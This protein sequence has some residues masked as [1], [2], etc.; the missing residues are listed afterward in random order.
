MDKP[1]RS[2]KPG[3]SRDAWLDRI[4]DENTKWLDEHGDD[5]CPHCGK[6]PI[7]ESHLVGCPAVHLN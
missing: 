6:R 7:T 2:Q 1:D 5:P 3:E 4:R